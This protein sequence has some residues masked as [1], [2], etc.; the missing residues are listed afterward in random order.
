MPSAMTP[1]QL[2]AVLECLA[3]LRRIG[4]KGDVS[5]EIV[6]YAPQ[7]LLGYTP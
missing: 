6:P 7:L 5:L 3:L 1:S 4:Y 2:I